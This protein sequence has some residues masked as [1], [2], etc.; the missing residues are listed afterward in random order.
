MADHAVEDDFVGDNIFI[1]RGGRAPLHITHALIDESV[2][3][4]E[5]EAFRDCGH[6]VQVDNTHVGIRKIGAHAFNGCR[7][8]PQINLKSAVE[9]EEYAF[10]FCRNLESVE[11]GDRLER[12]GNRAF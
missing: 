11:F 5:G 7:S 2:N 8:L 12:I 9:I 3:E 4:I 10:Y 6:L 1:Y